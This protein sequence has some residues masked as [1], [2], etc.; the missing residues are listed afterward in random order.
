MIAI[1]SIAIIIATLIIGEIVVIVSVS[2]IVR[3]QRDNRVRNTPGQAVS[4]A[5][6]VRTAQFACSSLRTSAPYK[7]SKQLIPYRTR[8]SENISENGESSVLDFR[9][10]RH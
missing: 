3:G 10:S 5:P 9:L 1:I 7:E 4:A 6:A 8:K 2:E